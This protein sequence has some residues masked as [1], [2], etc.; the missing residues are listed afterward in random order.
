MV[1][2]VGDSCGGLVIVVV[3]LIQ[4][5]SPNASAR[6]CGYREHGLQRSGSSG[7]TWAPESP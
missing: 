3:G 1:M 6:A 5:I 2:V 4:S 7:H